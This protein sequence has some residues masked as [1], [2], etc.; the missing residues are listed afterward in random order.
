MIF[1]ESGKLF[2]I[3]GILSGIVVWVCLPTLDRS[4]CG[5]IFLRVE[6]VSTT[7]QVANEG[8]ARKI[9]M[10]KCKV[11]S[12]GKRR[13]DTSFLLTGFTLGRDLTVT[14]RVTYLRREVEVGLVSFWD[15]V[16]M[17][18]WS[19][20]AQEVFLLRDIWGSPGPSVELR[21]GHGRWLLAWT[22]L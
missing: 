12:F 14:L 21:Q 1:S 3:V 2:R 11:S 20:F 9:F 18:S 22:S 5:R 13:H 10:L 16:S 8:A 4:R 6:I 7:I 19:A 17:W 15:R